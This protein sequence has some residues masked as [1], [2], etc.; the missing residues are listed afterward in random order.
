MSEII[1]EHT[2]H[3]SHWHTKNL[4]KQLYRKCLISPAHTYIEGSTLDELVEHEAGPVQLQLVLVLRV[5]A[6]RAAMVQHHLAAAALTLPQSQPLPSHPS[7]VAVG[8]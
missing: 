3:K 1:D 6:L 4:T 2:L 8:V 5:W 7:C